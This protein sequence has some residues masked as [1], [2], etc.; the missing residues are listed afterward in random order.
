MAAAPSAAQAIG[1][2]SPARPTLL[3]Q[4]A[5]R[6]GHAASLICAKALPDPAVYGGCGGGCSARPGPHLPQREGVLLAHCRHHNFILPR[7][8]NNKD[9]TIL[10]YFHG[11]YFLKG[12]FCTKKITQ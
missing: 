5:W 12:Q 10:I 6:Q 3:T 11:K 7:L 4:S 2:L 9:A 8:G 1:F